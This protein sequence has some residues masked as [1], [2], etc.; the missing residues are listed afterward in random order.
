MSL[1]KT[2]LVTQ[3]LFFFCV[4]LGGRYGPKEGFASEERLRTGKT[5]RRTAEVFFGLREKKGEKNEE[6]LR[7][8]EKTSRN[9][10]ENLLPK[11]LKPLG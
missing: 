2:Y 10:I 11:S 3:D 9:C 1:A 6:D 5:S 8:Y 4:L 7:S